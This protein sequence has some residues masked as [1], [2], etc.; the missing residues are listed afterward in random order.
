MKIGILTQTLHN[1]YGGLLQNY[2]LHQVLIR[3]DHKPCTIDHTRTVKISRIRKIY[4]RAKAHVKHWLYPHKYGKLA[5]V[6]NERE[7]DIISKNTNYFIDKYIKRTKTFDKHQDFLN[8]A[9]SNEYQ[10]YVVGSDQC[11]RP[12]YNKSFLGEMFLNFAEKQQ[13]IKRIAYA[14]SFGMDEWILS[15]ERIDEYARLAQKFDLITVRED[16]GI[17]LCRK[18]LGVQAQHVLDPTMLLSKDDYIRIVEMEK[19]PQS[20]G[21]LFYYILDPSEEKTEFVKKSAMRLGLVPFTVMPK[22]PRGY[23]TK[24]NI[25]NHIEDCAYPSVTSWL[26]AFMDAKMV[27]VDSFHGMVFSII[28]NKPFVVIGNKGRGMSRFTSLLRLFSLEDRLLDANHLDMKVLDRPI[29]WAYVNKTK[30]NYKE[31]ST[32]LLLNSLKDA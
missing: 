17:D 22:H 24:N 29:D 19:E 10:A 7:E 28:F 32:S 12:R 20:S 27:I 25:K 2:A 11:W 15:Q 31:V 13:T 5:Y 3:A 4:R 9:N 23:R 14:A 16:S 8:I 6:A 30:E 18:H 26:R 21:D 1:N